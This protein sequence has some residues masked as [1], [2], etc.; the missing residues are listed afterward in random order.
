MVMGPT[1]PGTGVMA[2]A[3]FT[4]CPPPIN[5][6]ASPPPPLCAAAG[7][8]AAA[9]HLC[10]LDVARQSVPRLLGGV[11]HAVHAHVDYDGARLDPRS[12]H[13][14][15]APDG[16]DDHVSL[17]VRAGGG[18]SVTIW[19]RRRWRWRRGGGGGRRGWGNA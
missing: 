5:H 8:A 1:P 17:R 9:A 13:K 6:T 4:A 16:G 7:A 2:P 12:L 3:T 19:E 14:L 11:R 15:R 10:K 18:S